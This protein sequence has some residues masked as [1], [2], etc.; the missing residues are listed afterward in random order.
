MVRLLAPAA[1][2]AA[3]STA[4]SALSLPALARRQ[5]IAVC[6]CGVID[7]TD[8]NQAMW[9]DYF[10]RDFR[11]M[12][13]ADVER[14]FVVMSYDIKRPVGLARSYEPDNMRVDSEG[15]KLTVSPAN[16]QGEVPSAGILTKQCVA[17]CC[18]CQWLRLTLLHLQQG[19]R[20]WSLHH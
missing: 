6:D 16:D 15:L 3:A 20:L 2:L 13:R 19:V 8:P 7:T 12:S 4:A 14:D 18:N 10:E 1:L 17:I 11:T 5:R 9:T